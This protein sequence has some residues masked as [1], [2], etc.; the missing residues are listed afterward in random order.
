MSE[1]NNH[2]TMGM[3]I[4]GALL[5]A[6]TIIKFAI[7]TGF[8]EDKETVI[9]IFEGSVKGLSIGAPVTLRGVEIGQVT[10]I[11][12]Q[13]ESDSAKLIMRVE[14]DISGENIRRTGD[15]R[16]D[17]LD[18]MIDH[19][20][21]AQLNT[22]SILTGLLYV[23]MDFHPEKEIILV[24]I[25]TPYQQIPT[26]PTNLERLT[27]ELESFDL[28]KMAKDIE[29]IA[30]NVSKFVGNEE[31]Q[32]LPAQF[33]TAIS[34]ITALSVQLQTQVDSTGSRLDN[35][36]DNTNT[37]VNLANAELPEIALLVQ[38]N[39]TELKQAINQFETGMQ[40]F[41]GLV[42]YD[43][44]TVYELN[45]TLKELGEAGRS[46]KDLVRALEEKPESLLRGRQEEE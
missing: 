41:N 4:V 16:E 42:D 17:L 44:T 23:Q 9:M 43:S 15:L 19:G 20:L 28:V 34:S 24:D 1:K 33:S 38:K 8:G 21:K 3:F 12:L 5:I 2:F 37:T 30:T 39:L 45:R 27:Q 10:A 13:L 36:L 26:I 7:G 22:Q 40:N 29:N 6:V 14:A 25:N 46:L 32:N 31:F 35:L 11:E 18:E